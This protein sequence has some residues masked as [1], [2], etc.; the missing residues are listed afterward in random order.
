MAT[1]LRRIRGGKRP[2]SRSAMAADA[3][4]LALF[5]AP[6]LLGLAGTMLPAFGYLPELG[7]TSFTLEPWRRLL[8][9]PGLWS[10]AA[11]SLTTGLATA[12]LSF[13]LVVAFTAHWHG[14][15]WFQAARRLLSPLLSVPHAAVAIGFAFL[16]APSGWV[17]RL[18]A[19]AGLAG[20]LPPDLATLQDPAGLSLIL[21][22]TLK[23]T[24]FVLLMTLVAMG[25]V[26]VRE[27]M[28]VARALG[29]AQSAAWLATVLPQIYPQLRLPIYAVLAYSASVVAVALI[30]GPRA[31]PTRSARMSPEPSGL[32]Y[33][34][35]PRWS[36]ASGR[37]MNWRA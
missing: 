10:A 23:E 11:L 37:P 36:C 2:N 16:I 26:R 21:G 27:G 33:S 13:A 7:G 28:T 4:L 30:L 3:A 6:V 32:I 14:T 35:P 1:A 9:V 15:A 24:P 31:P 25:Q 22:L 19:G 17:F 34:R 29:H 8:Q 18:L 20:P 5:A 12:G